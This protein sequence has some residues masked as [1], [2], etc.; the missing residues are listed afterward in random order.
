ML[1][2]LQVFDNPQFSHQE[3]PLDKLHR[4]IFKK[5]STPETGNCSVLAAKSVIEE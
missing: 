2:T 4:A 1:E 3:E 5:Q